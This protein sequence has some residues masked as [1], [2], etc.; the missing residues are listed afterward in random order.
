LSENLINNSVFSLTNQ[1]I[2]PID[3]LLNLLLISVLSYLL[4]LI[5][6]KFGNS[7]SNRSHLASSFPLL[8]LA[9]MVVIT[10]VKSSLALSLGLVG[11]LSIVRFRTPIK[12]PEELIYIFLCITFGLAVG[13]NQRLIASLS[14]FIVAILNIIIKRSSLKKSSKTGSFTV[15]IYLEKLNSN[16]KIINIFEKYCEIVILKRTSFDKVQENS[17]LGLYVELSSYKNI[18]AI[19]NEVKKLSDNI[20]IDFIENSKFIN[21]AN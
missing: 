9:T 13:A 2:S 6:T 3:F 18:E 15:F 19:T 17:E 14:L 11:A 10:V 4:G 12:E 16:E 8:G 21:T 1:T 5:Y 20:K 7:L